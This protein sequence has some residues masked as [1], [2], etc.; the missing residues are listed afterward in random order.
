MR[1]LMIPN[2]PPPARKPDDPTRDFRPL[3]D[4]MSDS[5]CVH[6]D[7]RVV[8][9]NQAFLR[10]LGRERVEDVVGLDILADI[11]HPDDRAELART[12]RMPATA[13]GLESRRFRVPRPDGSVIVI[14]ISE[15]QIVDFDGAPARLV[16]GRDIT[17]R[18]RQESAA[19]VADRMASI[20]MLA[21]GVAH[22]VN[23]P[24]AYVHANL[25]LA[26][27]E[28]AASGSSKARDAI[29]AARE[30]TERVHDIMRDL[31][32][33]ARGD[34]EHVEAVD[35][36]AV[37]KSAV[38]LARKSIEARAR[39]VLDLANGVVVRGNRARLG[40][41][42]LNLLVNAAAA[43]ADGAPDANTITVATKLAENGAAVLSVRD[44]GCGIA[45]GDLRRIFDPFFTT[46]LPGEGTGLGLSI[47]HRIVTGFGGR[48][49]VDS[50]LGEGTT[51]RVI[52]EALAED[53]AVASSVP[54]ASAR[55]ATGSRPKVL[56]VDD[57][58]GILSVLSALLSEHYAVT[59]AKDA[60][61]AL[62]L[63]SSDAS[64]D[65]VLCDLMMAG[66]TG[67]A[68]HDVLRVKHPD[69]VRRLVFMT[70]GAF[71][72]DAP[73][74][75]ATTA[76]PWIEKPFDMKRLLDVVDR[77]LRRLRS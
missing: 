77:H 49:E 73:A 12:M 54:P 11:V 5:V 27:R 33:L 44:T 28:L 20:G 55:P 19:V 14:E 41:V 66:M 72:S 43:I 64:Y 46:K 3:L 25:V 30:G 68:F 36:G 42:V 51:F 7:G 1:T 9:G 58:P 18:R 21:A 50:T 67:I 57:E 4:K 74:F 65:I 76:Q 31:N 23:N 13:A 62:E 26:E 10:Q 75:L 17:E 2:A 24:L 45:P 63:L 47:C 61:A 37:V 38:T 40:Q 32:T 8:W 29:A 69:L 15:P 70:G 16:V 53:A 60:Q 39:L 59:T 35:L 22:E 52:L 6:R 34:Q 71:T 48:I 56:V